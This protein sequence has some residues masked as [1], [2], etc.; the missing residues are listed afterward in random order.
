LTPKT[1]FAAEMPFGAPNE[2]GSGALS[3]ELFVFHFEMFFATCTG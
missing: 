1:A 3:S 2:T